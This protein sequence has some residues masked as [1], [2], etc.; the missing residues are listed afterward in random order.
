GTNDVSII[1]WYNL[2]AERSKGIEDVPQR[3]VLT[4]LWELPFFQQGHPVKRFVLAAGTSTPSRHWRVDDRS[5]STRAVTR[6]GPTWWRART[7]TL[8]TG[9]WGDG[10]TPQP[11]RFQRLSH[12]ATLHAPFQM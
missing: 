5:R 2:R 4:A 7:P 1:N 9:H 11:T 10:S 3:L 6:T 8:V 12:M